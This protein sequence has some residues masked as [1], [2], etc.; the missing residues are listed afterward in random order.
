M[1]HV[2]RDDAEALFHAL[3]HRTWH[4]LHRELQRRK[5]RAEG[6]SDTLIDLLL[7]ITREKAARGEPF[8]S[9]AHDLQEAL[10]QALAAAGRGGVP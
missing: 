9:S 8:P 5:G 7:P 1:A 10:N 2:P 6:I 4:E 3:H